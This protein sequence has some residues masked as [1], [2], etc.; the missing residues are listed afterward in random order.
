MGRTTVLPIGGIFAERCIYYLLIKN[1]CCDSD[2]SVKKANGKYVKYI[3]YIE[4][5]GLTISATLCYIGN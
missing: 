5:L 4:L 2:A 1:I 3:P